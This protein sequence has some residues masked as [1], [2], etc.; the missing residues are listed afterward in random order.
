MEYERLD[1]SFKFLTAKVP[2][3]ILMKQNMGMDTKNGFLILVKLLMVF[4]MVFW[5]Q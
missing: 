4:I 2:T 1:I 3:K 5:N